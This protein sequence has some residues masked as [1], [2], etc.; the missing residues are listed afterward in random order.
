MTTLEVSAIKNDIRN[1]YPITYAWYK[2]NVEILN[3]NNNTL[4]VSDEGNYYCL[5]TCGSEQLQSTVCIVN[6]DADYTPVYTDIIY[7]TEGGSGHRDGTS[8]ENAYSNIASALVKADELAKNTNKTKEIWV[9]KGMYMC[10]KPG[11]LHSTKLIELYGGFIGNET[12]KDARTYNNETIISN[13]V[14]SDIAMTAP[15]II[16]NIIFQNI[17][18]D[19][20]GFMYF[21]EHSTKITN[22][23]FKNNAVDCL[24]YIN[25]SLFEYNIAIKDCAF[26]NNSALSDSTYAVIV[27]NS[28]TDNVTFE[29]CTFDGNIAN[30]NIIRYTII[31]Q[32]ELFINCTFTHNQILQSDTANSIICATIDSCDENITNAVKIINCTFNNEHDINNTIYFH[33]YGSQYS[34]AL[35]VN[36]IIWDIN[37]IND[38][39]CIGMPILTVEN[40]ILHNNIESTPMF[41]ESVNVTTTNTLTADPLLQSLS[42]NGGFVQTC[43]VA[44][45]S[46]AIGAGKVIEGVTTDARGVIRSTTA[47]TIGAYEY[48]DI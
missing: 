2:D 45:G 3:E 19:S 29:N 7:V 5:V 32:N 10:N 13:N 44:N 34:S 28:R 1:L 14:G 22:C 33:G 37:G 48:I 46:P 38:I 8:W 24:L 39:K 9:A 12:I 43:A 20:H 36:C 11:T 6:I 40:C 42:D 47:P 35:V 17:N 15:S 41:S 31:N 21:G 26:I 30:R 25:H 18:Y 16:D 23:I 4:E 27:N